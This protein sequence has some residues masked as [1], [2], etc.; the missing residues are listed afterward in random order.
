MSFRT[1]LDCSLNSSEGLEKL[2][3]DDLSSAFNKIV[4]Q[5]SA[6]EDEIN[7]SGVDSMIDGLNNTLQDI[8]NHGDPNSNIK[9]ISVL[10]SLFG[11]DSPNTQEDDER[12]IFDSTDLVLTNGAFFKKAEPDSLYYNNIETLRRAYFAVGRDL[13][14]LN[15]EYLS[16]TDN[17]YRFSLDVKKANPIVSNKQLTISQIRRIFDDKSISINDYITLPDYSVLLVKK[18]PLLIPN[19]NS[20]ELN[21]RYN[22]NDGVSTSSIFH[23]TTPKN[24][25]TAIN[26][27]LHLGYESELPSILDG[28]DPAF[29]F[30]VV[31]KL[32]SSLQELNSRLIN[33]INFYMSRIGS[34][35]MS[36]INRIVDDMCSVSNNINSIFQFEVSEITEFDTLK[37]L[38]E[39]L[40]DDDIHYLFT[41]QKYVSSINLDI[42]ESDLMSSIRPSLSSSAGDTITSTSIMNKTQSLKEINYFVVLFIL[43]DIQNIK[44]A[45]KNGMTKDGLSNA[46]EAANTL[47]TRQFISA[48]PQP[49]TLSGFPS[50]TS[51][52]SIINQRMD[53]NK[54]FK[55]TLAC[56]AIDNIIGD[57]SAM[58]DKYIGKN[59]SAL[60]KII[61]NLV[62]KAIM[63]VNQLRDRMLA[64]ILPLKRKLDQFISKYLTLIGS[65]D[66]G[67]SVLKCAV[68]FDIGLDTDIFDM[69][70][71]AITIL[72]QVMNRLIAKLVAIIVEAIEKIICPV[73]SMVDKLM[74]SANSYLPSFCSF[75]SPILLPEDAVKALNDL[76]SIA[77][78]Q[79]SALDSYNGDLIKARAAIETANDRLSS[80]VDQAGCLN[81][82]A[83]SL[84][85]ST[86]LNTSKGINVGFLGF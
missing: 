70:A 55:I 62:K 60:F 64:A 12:R 18:T 14:L 38:K 83:S 56:A 77:S 23:K 34:I 49:Q 24:T 53:I 8:V 43:S 82:T 71:A 3:T 45:L 78:L 33:D 36:N 11:I 25:T 15:E 7:E 19:I 16:K 75:N 32:H 27:W 26:R 35:G 48:E 44:D 47:A 17:A 22:V 42:S 67:S 65:G 28:I 76:R 80:F 13:N 5:I 51:A 40:S 58:Y 79:S 84:M 21:S 31:S 73:I 29:D 81:K 69:L 68:N 20:E 39:R 9:D 74:G 72:A 10:S 46:L 59:I 52:S 66:F 6:V 57:I 54:N 85:S 50:Y 2:V 63:M 86:L 61:V 4:D 41:T 37:K 30:D 1:P